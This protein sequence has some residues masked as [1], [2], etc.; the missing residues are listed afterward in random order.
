MTR[1]LL[2][3][4]DYNEMMY[5]QTLLKK[6][7]FDVEA[8]SQGRKFS[9]TSLGFNPRFIVMSAQGKNVN[10]IELVKKVRKHNGYPKVILL[11]SS[12]QK[13][14]A[15]DIQGI[16]VDKIQETPVNILSLVR[17]I[18]DLDDDIKADKFE[19]LTHKLT[20]ILSADKG[21]DEDAQVVKST[22]EEK[23]E[24]IHIKGSEPE[25]NVVE[26]AKPT[27]TIDEEER[28]QK[29]KDF[30]DNMVDAPEGNGGFSKKKIKE[31]NKLHEKANPTQKMKELDEHKKT[32]VKALYS[33]IK[34]SS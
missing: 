24:L 6:L 30:L 3:I 18:C 23:E 20:Q 26:I 7:G 4:D 25:S 19:A 21:D 12:S 9:D 28:K 33:H 14:S 2:V 15:Q 16:E 1:L 32:F 5:L 29:Y 10:G 27:T 13:F 11:K 22:G 8:I 31:Y 34:K 17:G